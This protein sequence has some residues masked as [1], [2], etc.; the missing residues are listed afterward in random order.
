MRLQQRKMSVLEY[1]SK[2]I[3]LYHFAPTY[4]ADEK[5]KMNRFE[6]G[7]NRGLKEKMFVWHYTS[8]EDIYVTPPL[9]M[10]LFTSL[11][12]ALTTIIKPND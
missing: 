2:F 12:L 7:I 1:S 11:I 10:T 9:Y 5:L 6:T 3:E 8:Y 4:V